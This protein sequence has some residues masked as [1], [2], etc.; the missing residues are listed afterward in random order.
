M[1]IEIY[2]NSLLLLGIGKLIEIINLPN[3]LNIGDNRYRMLINVG[4]TITLIQFTF[5]RNGNMKF[6]ISR[7]V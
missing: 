4:C 3:R 6:Y 7:K 5:I 1:E 2:R